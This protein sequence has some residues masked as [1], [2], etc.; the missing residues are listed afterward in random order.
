MNQFTIRIRV[1]ILDNQTASQL[2]K[3]TIIGVYHF[4]DT[5]HPQVSEPSLLWAAMLSALING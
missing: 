3:Y 4:S 1:I 2:K 5:V